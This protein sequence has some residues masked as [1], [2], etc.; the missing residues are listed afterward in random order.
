[1]PLRCSAASRAD[2]ERTQT[3]L[4]FPYGGPQL[5]CRPTVRRPSG[6]EP[7]STTVGV[8]RCYSN[9]EYGFRFADELLVWMSN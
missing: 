2:S 4:T 1:M 7:R 5:R 9:H 6:V 3:A 8:G